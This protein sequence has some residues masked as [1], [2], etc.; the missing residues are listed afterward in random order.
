M[1]LGLAVYVNYQFS[2]PEGLLPTSAQTESQKNYGDAQLVG[3][4]PT[5]AGDVAEG[6]AY[7]AQAKVL[8][9]KSRDESVETLTGML[10]NAQIDPNQRAEMAMKATELAQTIEKEGKIENLMKAK[11]FT[12]CMVYYDTQGVDVVVR[13][14]GLDAAQVAQMKDIILQ[15]TSVPVENISIVEING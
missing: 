14:E 10:E 11:G 9:Q 15:E 3:A 12:D 4:N 7:F 5:V 8:R 6:E 13:T 1:G 2:D